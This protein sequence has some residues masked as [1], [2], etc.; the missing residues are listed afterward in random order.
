MPVP[1]STDMVKE[2]LAQERCPPAVVVI[3]ADRVRREQLF[4]TVLEKFATPTKARDRDAVKTKSALR[5]R[6]RYEQLQ[7]INPLQLAG[8]IESLRDESASLSLFAAHRFILVD[9]VEQ[10]DA[11]TQ[12]G[13]AELIAALGSDVSLLLGADKLPATHP[14][15]RAAGKKYPVITLAPLNDNDL[16]RWIEK[17]LKN[18]GIGEVEDK[19]IEQLIRISGKFPDELA[20]MVD[21]LATYLDGESLSS[22]VINKLFFSSPESNEFELIDALGTENPGALE[23][24]LKR[25]LDQGKSPFLL[26]GLLN[27]IFSN[28]LA[29][30]LLRAQGVQPIAIREQLA[31]SAWVFDKYQRAVRRYS[32]A[33][34]RQCLEAI[35]HAD[36]RLK[37]RSLGP[38]LVLSELMASLSPNAAVAVSQSFQ[39]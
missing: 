10:C 14:V 2:L 8:L 31:I 29:I 20:R 28:Y 34:L 12:R 15:I 38:D 33:K 36:Q 17:Q 24:L 11:A 27:R 4:E 22:K 30:T 35:L 19:S 37:N 39:T 21:Y 18:A 5:M 6:P 25:N 3:C 7:R 26:I 16:R 23:L 32:A 9:G 1:R 13:L